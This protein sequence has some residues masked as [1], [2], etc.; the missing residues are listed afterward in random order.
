MIG[1]QGTLVALAGGL[2]LEARFLT[3]LFYPLERL[4]DLGQLVGHESAHGEAVVV[5]EIRSGS[6][7]GN[8]NSQS[9][10]QHTDRGDEQSLHLDEPPHFPHT[11]K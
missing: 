2:S 8:D 7:S 9:G 3:G 1:H 6:S 10:C 5:D 4:I 11:P